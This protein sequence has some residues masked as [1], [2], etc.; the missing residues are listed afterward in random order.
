MSPLA[1]RQGELRSCYFHASVAAL[2]KAVPDTM[3]QAI[4]PEPGGAYPV[5]F[6]EEAEEVVFPEDI[7]FATA[8]S[9]PRSEGE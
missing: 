6:L 5:H 4:M 2:A 9:F 7:E 3:R 1:V 8:H